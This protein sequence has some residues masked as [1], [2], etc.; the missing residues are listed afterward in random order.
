MH[1]ES[2]VAPSAVEQLAQMG[3]K[4]EPSGPYSVCAMQGILID[5]RTGGPAA[6]ADPRGGYYAV[7]F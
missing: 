1:L 6:G 2:R 3:H 5:Q 7:G 4:I